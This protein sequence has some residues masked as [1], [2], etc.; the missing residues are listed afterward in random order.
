MAEVVVWSASEEGLAAA[1]RLLGRGLRERRGVAG[2]SQVEAAR[3]AGVSQA[4]YSRAEQ[5]LVVLGVVR[6]SMPSAPREPVAR[7]AWVRE[8]SR[9]F[10]EGRVRFSSSGTEGK[11][12][13]RD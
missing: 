2:L 12:V 5:G 8:R 7:L 9:A 13:A 6:D 4:T 11:G 10:A 3:A 1:R